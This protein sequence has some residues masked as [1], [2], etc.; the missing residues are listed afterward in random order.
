[1]SNLPFK[2]VSQIVRGITRGWWSRVE[3]FIIQKKSNNGFPF[4]SGLKSLKTSFHPISSEIIICS[5]PVL[6]FS[7]RKTQYGVVK[8]SMPKIEEKKL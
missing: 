2:G 3:I 5:V 1:M 7:V 6:T 4:L 8:R